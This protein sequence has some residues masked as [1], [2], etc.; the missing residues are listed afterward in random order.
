MELKGKALL[1]HRG[2]EVLGELRPVLEVLG[3]QAVRVHGC[4]EL[5]SHLQDLGVL[6]VFTEAALSDGCYRDVC[7]IASQPATPLPVIVVSPVVDMDLYLDSM[8][9]GASDFMVPPFLSTDVAHVLM[10]ALSDG[11][12]R[13][14]AWSQRAAGAA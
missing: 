10:T 13:R 1:V 6:A 8:E 11:L 12:P 4:K 14:V 7:R 3:L 2:D 9:S 5:Q